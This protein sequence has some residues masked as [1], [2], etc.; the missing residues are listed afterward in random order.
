[1]TF[2]DLGLLLATGLFAGFVGGLFGIGGGVVIV[3]VLYT[4]LGASGVPDEARIKI[5]VGTSLA[6]IVLTSIRSLQGHKRH[7]NVD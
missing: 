4:V 3:P 6:T 5:A 7:G 1:M 2:F